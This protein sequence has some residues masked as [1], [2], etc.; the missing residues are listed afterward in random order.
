MSKNKTATSSVVVIKNYPASPIHVFDVRVD[1]KTIFGNPFRIE[2]ESLRDDALDKYQ[3]Y[4]Y[5]R[6]KKDLEFR[7]EAERLLRLYEKYGTLNLFCW[8]F[9]KRCHSETI[10]DYI[11][12][13]TKR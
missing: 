9:P 6:I 3:A 11:T 10:R 2:D 4:F 7:N 13:R 8:C 5:E 12:E 1:R